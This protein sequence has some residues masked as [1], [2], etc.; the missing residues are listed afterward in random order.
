MPA[1]QEFLLRIRDMAARIPL[2]AWAVAGMILV[3]LGVVVWL[4]MAGPP[5]VVLDEGL[6]PAEGGKVIAQLQKLSIPYQLQAAGNLILVPAPDLAQARLELGADQVPGSDVSNA[7]DKLENAPMTTSDLAQTTMAAQA[8]ESS[9]QQS[10]ESMK[11]IQSAQVYLGL[12][13]S[14]PFLAD[15]PRPTASVVITAAQA[16]AQMQGAAIANLVAGAVPGLDAGQ[17]TVETTSGVTVYPVNGAL[18]ANAQF[19][20][21]AQVENSAAT[22]ISL[23][24]VPLVGDGNFRTDVAADLDFTAQK[25]HQITYGPTHLSHQSDQESSQTGAAQTPA[26]GIPGALSNEPPAATTA[27]TPGSAAAASASA[28]ASA[29][30]ATPVQKTSNVE[31]N[32][33][34]DQ[35]ESDITAPDWAI[36]SIAV[37]VVLNKAALGSV[38]P[39]QVKAAIA[40][41]FPYR[42][43]SVTVVAAAFQ[44]ASTAPVSA[45][46]LAATGPVSHALLQLL[47]AAGL[48][49]G[50][51]LPF[52][53]SLA[54]VN[55]RSLPAPQP[56]A[57]AAAQRQI[58]MNLPPPDFT[59]LREQA[60]D[61][62]AGVA[63]LLQSWVEDAE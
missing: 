52:G 24:L 15:Q 44:P 11:G 33:L 23:L 62:I 36:K 3:S 42:Q 35:T 21:V 43:V 20:T 28:N 13:P 7:W 19:A 40:G 9:L 26:F 6:S 30:T 57:A 16:D 18:A 32:F 25:T 48:L 14:T 2:M 53:R 8:L 5:Y 56:A 51:A 17:V 61:N 58:A 10:I 45:A 12:P 22:R 4:E 34:T 27:N 1:W 47:A 31:Q 38:T 41:A 49:F 59:D 50:L 60:S 63:H 54:S 39:D 29:S 55:F 46:L 37:S